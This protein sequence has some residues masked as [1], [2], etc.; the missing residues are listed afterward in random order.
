M[1]LSEAIRQ[2]EN[3]L[4]FIKCIASIL[5]I[6]SHAYAFANGYLT[7]D[8]YSRLTAGKGDLGGL[9]VCVFFFYSGLL[10]T[11][12]LQKN[13]DAGRYF[14]RRF[15]R[16]YPAYFWVILL[17]TFVAGPVISSLS[18]MEYFTNPSTYAYLWNLLFV[19]KQ[20]L[21]G[22]FG[23]N[24]YGNAVNGPLWTVR[25]EICCYIA[26]FLG[27]KLGLLKKK[28]WFVTLVLYF[29]G[30]SGLMY[31]SYHGVDGL[32]AVITPI[33]MFYIGVVFAVFSEHLKL[34]AVLAWVDVVLFF[35]AS[36]F[37]LVF[38]AY[39]I[40]LPYALCYFAF[41]TK[42][43]GEVFHRLGEFSYETY[44]WGGFIGQL[45]TYMFGGYMNVYLNMLIT[46]PCSMV[47]GYLLRQATSREI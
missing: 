7:T 45:V 15:D 22:V 46:I 12:S 24:A 8:W 26:V 32:S 28:N 35:V 40:F 42:R 27:K 17:I 30:L 31:L 43:R 16:I 21:P 5:V 13:D 2:R 41:A 6:V 47:L 3:N 9:A 18:V 10:I 20:Y 29:L 36:A 19:G 33:T 25:L 1:Q 39:I 44:L 14:R 23:T 34:H 38:V 11:C 4:N 37:H